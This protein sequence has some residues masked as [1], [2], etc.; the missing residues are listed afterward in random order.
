MQL[1]IFDLIEK[2]LKKIIENAIKTGKINPDKLRMI[3]IS[4]TGDFDTLKITY[5]NEWKKFYYESNN[6][7]EEIGYISIHQWLD[8]ADNAFETRDKLDPSFRNLAT[9]YTKKYSSEKPAL[10]FDHIKHTLYKNYLICLRE[11]LITQ[12]EKAIK[13]V[14]SSYT[15][16]DFKHI[17]GFVSYKLTF[18]TE[19]NI[20]VLGFNH[21]NGVGPFYNVM[22]ALP[23]S[24]LT[25]PYL[26]FYTRKVIYMKGQKKKAISIPMI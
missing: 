7:G 4:P 23:N 2:K 22:L 11:E 21:P 6:E 25:Y 15:Q 5:N 14:A 10:N 1:N 16:K 9:T 20:Q 13:N 26:K 3:I 24:K 12:I 17:V 19:E 18:Y 8:I